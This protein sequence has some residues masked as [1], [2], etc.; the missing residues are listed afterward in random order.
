MSNLIDLIGKKFGKFTVIERSHNNK[1]GAATWKCLCD[2]GNIKTVSG[3]SLRN[4]A[5]KSCGCLRKMGSNL[6]HG[7]NKTGEQTRTYRSWQDM[8]KRCLNPNNKYYYNYGERGII[9]CNRWLDKKNGYA[10]FLEDMGECPKRYQLD[11]IDNNKGYYKENCRWTTSKINNRNRR[12]NHILKYNGKEECF[13]RWEEIT[14]IP[15]TTIRTR[16]RRGWSIERTL[17]TPVNTKFHNKGKL[18]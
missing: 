15:Q 12:N 3:I 11:R 10:N 7:H 8:K 1:K 17:T 14:G 16:I 6:K 13:A 2:C 18:R 5:I 4:G 9:I